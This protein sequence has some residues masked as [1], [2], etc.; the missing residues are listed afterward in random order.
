[1]CP[2]DSSGTGLQVESG[3][4]SFLAFSEGVV[5]ILEVPGRSLPQ[6]AMVDSSSKPALVPMFLWT[7]NVSQ[8]A[9]LGSS[10]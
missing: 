3:V 7:L 9:Q 8:S 4:P 10:D 6:G 5:Y 2:Q 1:M